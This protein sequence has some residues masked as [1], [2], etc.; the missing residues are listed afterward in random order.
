MDKNKGNIIMDMLDARRGITALAYLKEGAELP[1][2]FDNGMVMM[3]VWE[4]GIRMTGCHKN[5]KDYHYEVTW[6]NLE[7]GM[8]NPLKMCHDLIIH[9]LGLKGGDHGI[10]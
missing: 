3:E 2:H 5:G 8:M 6:F 10:G 9:E 7:N 1:W 4:E